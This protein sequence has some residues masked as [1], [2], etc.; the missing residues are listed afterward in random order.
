MEA[1]FSSLAGGARLR[2]KILELI[3]DAA[4]MAV[5]RRVEVHVMIFAF[6]DRAIS[7]A[8]AEAARGS[9][10]LTV[11]ILADWNQRVQARGQ[12]AGRLAALGLANLR[13][14][15]SHDQP[16]VW[17]EAAGHLRWSYRASRGLLH[18]K[19]LLVLVDG[20]PWR[21]ACGSFNWTGTAA[22]SY[23]NLL[24][25][26]ADEPGS[27]ELIARMELEFEALWRDGGATLS[28]SEAMLHYRAIREAYRRDP[29]AAPGDVAG[30]REGEGEPLQALDPDCLLAP[31]ATDSRVAIAFS[32]HDRQAGRYVGG[33]AEA[34]RRQ[35]LFLRKASGLTRS[36]PL[37]ITNL[38]LETVTR[39]APGDE[40]Q[41]AM[42][43]LSARVPE[44]GA[45]LDAARRGVRL[46]VLLDRSLA[47]DIPA[48]L[49]Q[50]GA[51]EGLPIEVR[52]TGRM[53]HQKYL[54]NARQSVVLTGTA[55]MSTDAAGRHLEHRIRVARAPAL[56]AQFGADFDL[57]WSRAIACG[58][59]V[60]AG[61]PPAPSA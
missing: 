28:P 39:A 27:R 54:L 40:L 50:A 55:N 12:Q 19:V 16:Y 25:A 34:N 59:P 60:T 13:V 7:E 52:T 18:H 4:A 6:T 5:A 31:A 42:Y 2:G 23:E 46:L 21:L 41:L 3:A 20:R 24:V 35:R 45:L 30:W 17:D 44:Y 51:L 61:Q 14:R 56:A 37:T 11:R 32:A 8:L 43:G 53:M 15:Y 58:Q 29:S 10:N 38:A 9:A 36:V 57:I 47:S 48:R 1:L 49:A 26:D 22:R 33:H